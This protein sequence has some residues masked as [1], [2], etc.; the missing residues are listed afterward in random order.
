MPN[1]FRPAPCNVEDL[2]KESAP[3]GVPTRP[4]LE[5]H[6]AE[7][8]GAPPLGVL[9][10]CVLPGP[11]PPP[12]RL[13]LP[14]TPPPEAVLGVRCS[15]PGSA[16]GTRNFNAFALEVLALSGAAPKVA[17]LGGTSSG[18]ARRR[19]PLP[20]PGGVLGPEVRSLRSRSGRQGL[21]SAT[22]AAWRRRRG[23]SPLFGNV[24]A[25]FLPKS[26]VERCTSLSSWSSPSPTREPVKLLLE[27]AAV[28]AQVLAALAP[29]AHAAVMV[30][31]QLLPITLDERAREALGVRLAFLA[32][33]HAAG[34]AAE[35]A[36]SDATTGRERGLRARTSPPTSA[37]HAG[38]VHHPGD[39]V[40]PAQRDSESACVRLDIV[41]EPEPASVDAAQDDAAKDC[42]S[43]ASSKRLSLED[44]L[45]ADTDLANPTRC[46]RGLGPALGHAGLSAA[47]CA[48]YWELAGADDSPKLWDWPLAGVPADWLLLLL[49]WRR[50]LESPR[51]LRQSGDSVRQ[52]PC[53][54]GVRVSERTSERLA[55]KALGCE[56]SVPLGEGKEAERLNRERWLLAPA[57]PVTPALP[58]DLKVSTVLS[59]VGRRSM[60][61]TSRLANVLDCQARLRH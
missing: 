36:A 53:P 21:S 61:R 7:R 58:S 49:L 20:A 33:S 42:I 12:P 9:S 19:R 41:E 27:P 46:H 18:S 38:M 30:M 11:C 1:I 34:G 40:W 59:Q 56:I 43:K 25:R 23:R 50:R 14:A 52:P 29:V 22:G 6:L 8:S 48:Q 16:S 37:L 4:G 26:P 51:P 55:L 5:W 47:A 35:T 60:K 45:L 28:G 17:V 2:F 10:L 24:C 32:A 39:G 15:A 44:T 3:V 13:I 54:E 31:P 57:A